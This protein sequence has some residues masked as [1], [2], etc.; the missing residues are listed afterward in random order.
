MQGQIRHGPG[1]NNGPD[2]TTCGVLRLLRSSMMLN[3][4]TDVMTWPGFITSDMQSHLPVH[5]MPLSSACSCTLVV[6]QLNCN[7]ALVGRPADGHM[8]S[9][10]YMLA[11]P[12]QNL[13]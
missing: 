8:S 3:N 2:I 11:R 7:F 10:C 13:D 6:L 9:Q 12:A 5:L 4:S 1:P